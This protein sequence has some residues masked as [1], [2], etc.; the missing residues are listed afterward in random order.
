MNSLMYPEAESGEGDTA[1][2]RQTK[3]LRKEE[4]VNSLL[5]MDANTQCFDG[6]TDSYVS[7]QQDAN[8][9]QIPTAHTLNI[10]IY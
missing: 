6:A 8:D 1:R 4:S 5:D 10:N 9:V 3:M 7:I 2:F